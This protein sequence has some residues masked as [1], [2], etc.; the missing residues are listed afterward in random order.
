MG[1]PQRPA[2]QIK[3]IQMRNNMCRT[4][5]ISKQ[6]A[7]FRRSNPEAAMMLDFM[8][9]LVIYYFKHVTSAP[10]V[11]Y[12]GQLALGMTMMLGTGQPNIL[13]PRKK[14]EG[15]MDTLIGKNGTGLLGGMKI[16]H[17]DPPEVHDPSSRYYS[18][19]IVDP[20]MLHIGDQI[21]DEKMMQ[22]NLY[23]AFTY[24]MDIND[25]Y[26]GQNLSLRLLQYTPKTLE[27]YV[28]KMEMMMQQH[29]CSSPPSKDIAKILTEK[30][31]RLYKATGQ[32]FR[33]ADGYPIKE[34][35]VKFS[36]GAT[37]PKYQL[38]FIC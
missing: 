33:T 5:V 29:H 26:P 6:E 15:W 4:E 13:I 30:A 12:S 38:V 27:G 24:P 16:R 35:E 17:C 32:V 36:E 34:M 2:R 9:T 31:N 23:R 20:N 11:F 1:A 19:E 7:D 28:E 21:T 10:K 3:E 14:L 18:F 8:L 25:Y 22:L 37:M